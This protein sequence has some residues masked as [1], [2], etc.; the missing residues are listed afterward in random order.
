MLFVP[1]SSGGLA[2]AYSVD[3][4]VHGRLTNLDNNE[5]IG[6]QYNPLQFTYE[7][8]FNWGAVQWRGS[9]LGGDLDYLG[10]GP[11]TFDLTLDFVAEPSANPMD[12]QTA[13]M[14]PQPN[15]QVDFENLEVTI[16]DWMTPL[17]G[18]RR[19]AR[20]NVVLG[21]R[22][23]NGVI[24]NYRFKVL[25]FHED[26]SARHGRLTMEFKQWEPTLNMQ[27]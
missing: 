18:K 21:P 6:F 24:L 8:E 20:I 3:S 4:V 27:P 14:I 26:L 2:Q 11:H 16:I 17:E 25:E 23:F 5:F 22:F 13:K 9:E 10:S 12:A 7:R 19:P 15:H 1:S